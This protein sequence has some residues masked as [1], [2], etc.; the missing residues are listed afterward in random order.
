MESESK[1]SSVSVTL[2]VLL[3]LSLGYI[4]YD[5]RGKS[6]GETGKTTS[7]TAAS[8]QGIVSNEVRLGPS[9]TGGVSPD[10]KIAHGIIVEKNDQG[11]VVESYV[12]DLPALKSA[13]VSSTPE[14]PVDSMKFTK[15]LH[16]T[17]FVDD[18]TYFP[19]KSF[20]E[21][22]IGD[23]VVVVSQGSIVA[24]ALVTASHLYNEIPGL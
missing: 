13:I 21:L 4:A 7:E 2:A 8:S 23:K 22:Q 16:F 24:G 19:F 11:F 17:A 9:V 5:S 15:P 18:S 6:V 3:V 20:D 10:K 1:H 14:T 12:Y